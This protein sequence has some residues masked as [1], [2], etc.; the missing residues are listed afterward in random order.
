MDLVGLLQVST[1][2]IL[3]A[4]TFLQFLDLAAFQKV[5]I[6]DSARLRSYRK[7]AGCFKYQ[8]PTL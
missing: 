6:D 8:L 7:K 5:V 1:D 2:I 4:I 3:K